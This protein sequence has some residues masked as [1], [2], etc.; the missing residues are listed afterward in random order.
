MALGEEWRREGGPAAASTAA[1]T[2]R[3]TTLTLTNKHTLPQRKV[4]NS[5]TLT[6]TGAVKSCTLDFLRANDEAG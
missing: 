1:E 5:L 6:T 4:T 3:P 2:N